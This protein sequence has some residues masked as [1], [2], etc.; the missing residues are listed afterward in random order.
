MNFPISP[1]LNQT[2][3]LGT[4]T[5]VWNGSA[6][7]LQ[8]VSATF[9]SIAPSQTGNSGKFLT[10]D[11]TDSSWATIV[12]GGGPITQNADVITT[13][14][15]IAS[16]SNGLSVGPMTINTGVTVTVATGQTYVVL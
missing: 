4:K 12:T 3:T 15:T 5:W 7:D 16:G 14:Q 8:V 10:T 1:T 13:N 6:W 11:G 2:Y 9:N